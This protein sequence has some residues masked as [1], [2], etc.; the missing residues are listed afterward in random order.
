ANVFCSQVLATDS[1]VEYLANNYVF[2]AWDVTSAS[3]RTRLF[4][5][6]RR[7]VGNQCVHRVG[8]IENDTF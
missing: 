4:E 5:T 8:S 2:W 3:N 6:V 1:I 7:C